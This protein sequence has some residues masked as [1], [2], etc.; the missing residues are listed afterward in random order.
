MA[1]LTPNRRNQGRYRGEAVDID[2]LQKSILAEAARFG[3]SPEV[4]YSAED[5]E[6]CALHRTPE[7]ARTRIYVSA[8]IHGDEPAGPVL[9]HELLKRND[10]P[11]DA[12]ILLIPC[13]NPTGFRL[14]TRENAEG[15]DLNRDYLHRRAAE[16]KAHVELLERLPQFDLML[17]LHEDWEARGFYLYEL[18]PDQRPSPAEEMIQRV[19]ERCPVDFSDVID[20]RP[21]ISGVVRPELDPESRTEWPEAFYLILQKTRW[22]YTLESPSDFDLKVRVAALGAAVDCVLAKV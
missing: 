4:F 12:E 2:A 8:G 22:S 5:R 11:F 18:N 7:S 16:T 13:L 21:A 10:W 14:S 19:A 15:I 3:W 1:P 20:G 17:C 6:L 9:M